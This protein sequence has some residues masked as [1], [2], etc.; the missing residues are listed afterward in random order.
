MKRNNKSKI[1]LYFVSDKELGS[2]AS[3]TVAKFCRHSM[4]QN[5]LA[6]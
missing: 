1:L 4:T 2:V 5:R 6:Y 3:R